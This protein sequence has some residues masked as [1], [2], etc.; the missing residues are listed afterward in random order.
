MAVE[1]CWREL[2]DMPENKDELNLEI[3]EMVL[4]EDWPTRLRKEHLEQLA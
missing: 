1:K 4:A 3:L 2:T